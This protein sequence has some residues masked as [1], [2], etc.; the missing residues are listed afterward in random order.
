MRDRRRAA[1][2][3]LGVLALLAPG[4]AGRA[5]DAGARPAA[6]D[7]PGVRAVLAAPQDAWNRGDLPGF[8]L[9][10]EFSH[11]NRT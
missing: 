10:A 5:R 3:A 6:D 11:D 8:M 7:A 9:S 4:C 1:A 2:L